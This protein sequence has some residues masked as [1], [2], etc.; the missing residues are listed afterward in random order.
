MLA[1]KSKKGGAAKKV[2]SE[3]TRTFSPIIAGVAIFSGIIN[4][5]ALSG[6][7]YMLQIYDRILPSQSVPTLVGLTILLT[8]LYLISGALDIVRS[9]IMVRVGNRIDAALSPQVFRAV[10]LMPLRTP[11]SAGI[12][13]MRDLDAIRSFMSGLGLPAMLDLPWMPI[14][15]IF[16]YL[17]HPML[18]L[19]A[20][21]GALLLVF[22]TLLA[23]FRSSGPMK[24][25]ASV[26]AERFSLA[27]SV[28][29]NAEAIQAMGM[30]IPLGRRY[31]ALNKDYLGHHL[32]AAD[33]AGSIGNITKVMRMLLQ[34]AVLGLGAYYVIQDQLS[35]GA[36]IAASIA[37]SRALSPI[38]TAIAHWK[39]F[40]S[41]RQAAN[42]LNELLAQTTELDQS[43]LDLPR[44][45]RRLDAENL[46][47]AGPGRT[48]PIVR[49]VSFSLEAS[50]GL[51]IV[52]PSGSGKSTLGRA[53][54][55]VWRCLN[56]NGSVR[57]DGAALDQW[58]IGQ[59]GRNIGYMPQDVELFAG[60]VAENIARFDPDATSEAIVAA[61]QASGS[62]EL[63]V[64]LPDGYQT[65]VGEGG[66]ALSGGER[67]RVALARALYGDPF[68]VV[69]DEPNSNLDSAGDAALNEAL[70][71]V[72]RRKG[73]AI[74]IAHRPTALAAVNKVLVM[75]NGMMRDF[76]PKDEVLR[77]VL[78]TVST[79]T[80]VQEPPEKI[81]RKDTA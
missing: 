70:I 64:R 2:I 1:Q 16:V 12:Q 55:G 56:P 39:G 35:P 23:D 60:T 9:R 42:R 47:I 4:V 72:R 53:L 77:R 33:S 25:A 62:H 61:A 43:V 73:I 65:R 40:V 24:A 48:E 18:A 6:S 15:L 21:I 30:S 51:G 58:H 17:L 79:P 20:V 13:P 69:L 38:E 8:G 76:G 66:R 5:L 46:I 32:D 27:E 63:I 37:V 75:A 54:V 74:V 41:A 7:I 11:A 57:L 71:S 22:L 14:Y 44:P 45:Q 78:Q 50:D 80:S 29:R 36:I 3:L 10:Q 68:L 67:Q 52:G 81:E 31:D 19:L 34:S 49:N 26:G 59:L 28:R